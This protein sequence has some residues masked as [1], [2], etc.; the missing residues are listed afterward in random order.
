M[1]IIYQRLRGTQLV[2][3]STVN[4]Q[5]SNR[6]IHFNR[7]IPPNMVS[8]PMIE[9]SEVEVTMEIQIAGMGIESHRG[10]ALIGEKPGSSRYQ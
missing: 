7:F 9:P 4:F 6:I 10:P 3:K 8:M 1:L 5:V 2:T